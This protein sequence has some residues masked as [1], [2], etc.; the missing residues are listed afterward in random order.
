MHQGIVGNI[1]RGDVAGDL[2]GE[3]GGIGAHI[4]VVGRDEITADGQVVVAI[5]AAG[6]EQDRR[7]GADQR[8]LAAAR[9]GGR[10][11]GSDF[12]AAAGSAAGAL[13]PPRLRRF[14]DRPV[15]L[16]GSS[17]SV[18]GSSTARTAARR[19]SRT[20]CAAL[21]PR[22]P[23]KRSETREIWSLSVR[24]GC[25]FIHFPL[26]GNLVLTERFGQPKLRLRA[27][28]RIF[29]RTVR[30]LVESLREMVP[31]PAFQALDRCNRRRFGART[32]IRGECPTC[33]TLPI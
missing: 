20:R 19:K 23:T 6:R 9:P 3:R 14:G 28:Q 2:G 30:S 32:G 16:L 31:T 24:R 1:D 25:I 10:L 13:G 18:R 8:Q 7:R 27:C 29:D 22:A 15:G 17:P 5:P 4:G 11:R 26:R 33:P 21:A 12:A